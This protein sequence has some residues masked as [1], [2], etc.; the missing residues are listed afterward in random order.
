MIFFILPKQKEN[1]VDLM[2]TIFDGQCSAKYTHTQKKKNKLNA[3]WCEEW[4]S[5]INKCLEWLTWTSG[6]RAS[7]TTL[8]TLEKYWA[9]FISLGLDISWRHRSIGT[10]IKT[11]SLPDQTFPKMPNI[12]K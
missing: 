8:M 10:S 6:V 4:H 2:K 7:V 5:M 3:V 1:A 9:V 11:P 12:R